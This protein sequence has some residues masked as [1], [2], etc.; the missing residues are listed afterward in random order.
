M[1]LYSNKSDIENIVNGESW[2][3]ASILGM[4]WSGG[5]EKKAIVIR[6]FLPRVD[7]AWIKYDGESVSMKKIHD[8][9]FFEAVFQDKKV[10]FKYSI[11][12]K[13]AQGIEWEKKDPYSFN[14]VISDFDLY[15]FSEGNSHRSY[16]ILGA[17]IIEHQSE[18]GVHFA[19]WAPNARRVSVVGDF[20][21]WD[22]REHQMISRGENGVW[23][24]F[25]PGLVEREL[26]K[27]EIK[28]QSGAILEK[29]DPYGFSAEIRPKTA[30]LIW[31]VN[32]YNWSDQEKDWLKQRDSSDQLSKPISIYEVHLGSWMRNE[33]NEYLTYGE[34]AERLSKYVKKMGYTHIELLPIMEFPFDGSW[35][36]QVTGFYAPTSRFGNPDDFKAFIEV[37]HAHGIGV[38]LDWVPAHF[39]V[40]E[41]GLS[42][43]DGT[44]LYE[45]SDPRKGFHNEWGTLIFNYGRN[46]VKSFLISNAVFLI[47]TYHIDGLRVD[48][49]ASMLYLDYSRQPGEWIPNQYG[50]NENLEAVV[51][52]KELN[53]VLYSYYPGIL[54]IAEES[55]SWPAV[56]RP[57]YIGGLGFGLKWNMG[58]MNDFLRYISK[59]P[60][61]RK[62]HHNDLTFGLIYAFHE[63]FVLVFSHDEVVHGKKS[64]LD[65]MPGDRWQKFA[66]LRLAF[67]YM[68]AHP[69]K[70]LMFQGA[71]FGQWSEWDESKSIDWHLLE[72]EDHQQMA[73]YIETLN[74]V[75]KKYPAFYELDFDLGGF[76]WIDFYD[77][78]S[79]IVSF[80]RRGRNPDNIIVVAANFTPVPRYDYRIGVPIHTDWIEILNSDS[81]IYGGSNMGNEG[82]FYSDEVPWQDMNYSLNLTIPPLSLIIFAPQRTNVVEVTGK[83]VSKKNKTSE[84]INSKKK[85]LSQGPKK[86]YK[87][88]T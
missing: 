9:G 33:N 15:L 52:L 31:D 28:T 83:V 32:K 50:G 79:S 13:N 22:G 70:K 4:H 59:E 2:N 40:D 17:H 44:A 81:E 1:S 56:S 74:R 37:M 23:E 21:H 43:F 10:F 65:K 29:A 46:E 24:M 8:S 63:N 55:T 61:Y 7:Q 84:K 42:M 19:V 77:W 3:P 69:G 20:N 58:W 49:V 82:G 51:F 76:E 60:I 72:W 27:F 38:I 39:P 54:T 18:S 62:Y 35:G 25:I 30:S 41:H 64:M 68:F 16:N 47:D 36:Y 86:N 71:E 57:T 14:N 34:L 78:E 5:K 26:Y 11:S 73:N 66:N 87:K 6:S 45:H 85:N 12:M 53:E 67:G 48:A 75:Y 88:K 80:I